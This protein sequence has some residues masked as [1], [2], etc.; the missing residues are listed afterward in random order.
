[1]WVRAL[2]Q[3]HLSQEVED[4]S[5]KEIPDN[6]DFNQDNRK[7]ISDNVDFNQGHVGGKDETN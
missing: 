3:E 4:D 7:E 6:I 2:Q 5:M 1:M